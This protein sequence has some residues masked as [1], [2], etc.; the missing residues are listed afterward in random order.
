MRPNNFRFFDTKN[1]KMLPDKVHEFH[2]IAERIAKYPTLTV[3]EQKKLLEQYHNHQDQSAKEK[4]ILHNLKLVLSIAIKYQRNQLPLIDIFQEGIFGLNRAIDKFDFS[5]NTVLSTY[6]TIWISQSIRRALLDKSTMIRVPV[7]YHERVMQTKAALK[8]LNKSLGREPNKEE[9]ADYLDIT[10]GVAQKRLDE[11]YGKHNNVGSLD[12]E[13]G[14]DGNT[15]VN[16]LTDSD[17]DEIKLCSKTFD[18]ETSLSN[19]RLREM[20][21]EELA[22]QSERAQLIFK[23]RFGLDGQEP[24]THMEICDY[25]QKHKNI[26][27][28]RQAIHQMIQR[29]ITN[30]RDFFNQDMDFYV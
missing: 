10:P 8:V 22:K 18:V 14:H 1:F 2:Y 28:T 13:L 24:M 19:Q 4:L 26:R 29:T 6:A 5:K 16:A 25:F 11:Y 7:H 12:F 23:L 20:L 27:I 3:T 30:L 9:L 15:L 21:S 17:T